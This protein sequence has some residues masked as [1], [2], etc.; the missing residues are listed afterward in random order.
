MNRSRFH[1]NIRSE[2]RIM[3]IPHVPRP[4]EVWPVEREESNFRDLYIYGKLLRN[5]L[6]I[7][8]PYITLELNIENPSQTTIKEIVAT[9]IQRRKLAK[10]SGQAIIFEQSLPGIVDFQ[11]THLHQTF[12]IPVVPTFEF[13]APTT[14]YKDPNNPTETWI[15]D[16]VLEVKFK[17]RLFFKNVTLE[18]PL[19]V[20]N[21]KRSVQTVV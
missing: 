15:F 11:D 10:R 14:Y 16:Y 2:L 1:R 13:F 4:R 5:Y 7:G 12:Q 3:V 6:L 9:L 19:L 8:E 20:V 21:S 17:T 18:F